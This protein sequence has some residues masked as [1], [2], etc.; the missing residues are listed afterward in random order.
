MDPKEKRQKLSTPELE[1]Q[2]LSKKD[3]AITSASLNSEVDV[4]EAMKKQ[5]DVAMFLAEK[6][7]SALARNSNFVFSPASISAVLTMVAVTSETETLRSFIFSIL[8]SSSIDE[9]N[10]VFHE[11]ANTVLVDGSENGG[12]KI[13]AVNGVWMEQSLSVSPSKKDSEQ[14]RMEVNEWASRHTNALIQNMLPP[15]SVRSDIDW[16]YGNAIYFKGAWKNKFPKSETSEEEFYHVD[17]TSVSV[18]FMT[19]TFRMQYVREYDDFKVLKLSFQ[20]GRDTNRLFSMYFY[21]P[22]EKDGL[23]NLV[24]RMASTPGFL[25]SHIPSEKVRVGEFRIPKFK[26]EFGFEASKAF[27]ELELESVELHHKAL[28]E[29][30]EDGAEAAAVT[31]KGGRRG[32]RGFSTVRLIDFVADHP[33]LFLIK[34][35]ITRTVMF[36]GQIFDPT[37]TSSA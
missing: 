24:K 36:V 7:I 10:A 28:V 5:N 20:R 23:E 21:L 34:E 32:R 13:S 35:D 19:T 14:V 15:T 29:I 9:L 12:P 33:F 26:I 2:S 6:V 8:S 4:G 22:D 1:S 16:I 27:N 31:I 30:D 25:D 17:G 3:V 18:P 11:V 37:K